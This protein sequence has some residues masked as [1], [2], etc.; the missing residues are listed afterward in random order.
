MKDR[1]Q[2]LPI[3][4]YYRGRKASLK[5]TSL[6]CSESGEDGRVLK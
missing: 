4:D 5:E 1:R 6:G 2:T 3:Q